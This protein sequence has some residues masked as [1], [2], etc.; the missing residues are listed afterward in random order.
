[1]RISDSCTV[2]VKQCAG[3]AVKSQELAG[4]GGGARVLCLCSSESPH[5]VALKKNIQGLTSHLDSGS[6]SADFSVAGTGVGCTTIT[7]S[8]AGQTEENTQQ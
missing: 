4:T 7:V 8:P 6:V 1:M 2:R 5:K 3:H